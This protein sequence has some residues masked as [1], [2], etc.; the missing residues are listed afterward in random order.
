MRV[1]VIGKAS[2]ATAPPTPEAFAAM[3]AFIEELDEAVAWAKQ[4]PA[5]A[6]GRTEMELRPFYEA[7]DLAEYLTPEDLAAPRTGERGKLGVA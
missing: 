4:S 2:E 6:P 1:M 7:S 3:D 5:V